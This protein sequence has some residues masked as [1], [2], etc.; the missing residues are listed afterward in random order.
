[1]YDLNIT[2]TKEIA[3]KI[4]NSVFLIEDIQADIYEI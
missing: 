1:M 4:E 2:T 3:E